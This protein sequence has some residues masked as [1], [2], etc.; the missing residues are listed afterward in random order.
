MPP[1]T[2]TIKQRLLD[3]LMDGHLAA[4]V[5]E[6]RAANKSWRE[7]EY[8][9]AEATGERVTHESLR[10]WFPEDEQVAS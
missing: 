4:F 10:A 9:V 5:A 3:A 8:D 7:I 6:R 2:S 1:P